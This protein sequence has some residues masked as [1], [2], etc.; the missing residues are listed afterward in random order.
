MMN[1]IYNRILTHQ[2]CWMHNF[3]GDSLWYGIHNDNCRDS[4]SRTQLRRLGTG[5]DMNL[6][7]PVVIGLT[8]PEQ[9]G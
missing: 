1:V 3:T 2:S 9:C 7:L 5:Q 8:A 4:V 6:A